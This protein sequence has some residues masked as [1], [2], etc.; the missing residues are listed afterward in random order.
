LVTAEVDQDFAL[1]TITARYED[2]NTA[3][4]ISN[5]VAGQLIAYARVTGQLGD[6]EQF[7]DRQ[8]DILRAEI[9]ALQARADAL[10]AVKEPSVVQ[11]AELAATQARLTEH[12]GTFATL[13]GLAVGGSTTGPQI[14]APATPAVRP[15]SPLVPLNIVLA[16]MVA[17]MV[18]LAVAFGIDHLD[19]TIKSPDD[20]ET[21]T[22]VP[23][24][25]GL[26][27]MPGSRRQSPVYRLQ[28]LLYPRSVGAERFRAVRTNIEFAALDKPLRTILLTSSAPREG[29]T[30][31]ATN[32]AIVFAQA[33]HSVLLVDA[34]LRRPGVHEFFAI[35]NDRGLGTLLLADPGLPIDRVAHRP[36]VDG[37]RVITTGPIPPNPA[38]LLASE[39]MARLV[40]RFSTEADIVI[41]DSPPLQA[42]TDAAILSTLADATVLVV[43]AGRTRR[44]AVQRSLDALNKVGARVHGIVLNRLPNRRSDPYYQYYGK[45]A[46][47][48]SPPQSS[49]RSGATVSAASMSSSSRPG[50]GSP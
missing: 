4:E 48:G 43:E 21:V 17:L 25:G 34:D 11:A 41:L 13:L 49:G 24:L 35:P 28:T 12:R 5:A 23:S 29:K 19:D 7:V 50:A 20:V 45:D 33:G 44:A 36:D 31:T 6:L 30:T 26:L 38:E 14:V 16:M 42:V 47:S 39:R 10:A 22:G 40:E 3:A 46:S 15:S 9:D 32:L 2:P 1:L 8:L 37:L 18:S 27:A